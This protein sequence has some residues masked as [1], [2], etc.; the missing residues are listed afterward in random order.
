MLEIDHIRGKMLKMFYNRKVAQ[1]DTIFRLLTLTKI[2]LGLK[3]VAQMAKFCL[4]EV[5]LNEDF[6][7]YQCWTFLMKLVTRNGF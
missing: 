6:S 3:K 5:T 4:N 1:N 7:L 2:N